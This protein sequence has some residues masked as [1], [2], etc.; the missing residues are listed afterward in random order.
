MAP[1]LLLL[2]LML[3][4]TVSL[5]ACAADDDDD[6]GGGDEDEIIE[7]IETSRH[8]H[9]PGNCT[10]FQTQRFTDAAGVHRAGETGLQSCEANAAETTGDPDSVE[11]TNVEVDGDYGHRR[12]P[13]SPAAC[14]TGPDV[15]LAWSRRATSGSSTS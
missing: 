2:L 4:L 13:P 14:S 15:D 6:G 7:V 10:E 9:G 1:R 3:V 11:V 12:G 8:Q 5:A